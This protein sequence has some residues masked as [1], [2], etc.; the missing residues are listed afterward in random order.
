MSMFCR[1]A[2]CA[3]SRYEPNIT[4]KIKRFIVRSVISEFS[5]AAAFVIKLSAAAIT[6]MTR[7]S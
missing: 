4:L 5:R 2:A 6:D 7:N 3:A 1:A